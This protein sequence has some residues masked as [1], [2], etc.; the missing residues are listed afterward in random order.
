VTELFYLETREKSSSRILDRRAR[1]S[2]H[3]TAFDIQRALSFL[4]L[5]GGRSFVLVGACWGA[6]LI[7]EGLIQGILEAPA[8][9]AAD[10]M[11]SIWFPKW[12]LLCVSPIVPAAV[13]RSLKPVLAWLMLRDMEEPWQKERAYVFV[14]GADARKWK[15][16]AEAA[17]DFELMGRLGA[18]SR[19]VFVLNG[20]RDK[21]HDQ[22]AYPRIAQEM[23]RGRF[24]F[25]PAAERNRELLFGV[26]AREFAGVSSDERL[27]HSLARFEKKLR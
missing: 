7:L 27:P 10:P 3:D 25:M 14:K 4:G 2:I 20:T 5:E 19:E 9:V 12:L 8:V 23:P 1:T 6:A 15:E 24:L 16:S 26:V 22:K 17:R 13:A 18:M 21:I 11:H